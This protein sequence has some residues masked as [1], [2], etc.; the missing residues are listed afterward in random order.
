[1]RGLKVEIVARPVEVHG[2][3]EDR[4]HSI[5][6][7]ISLALYEQHFLGQSVRGVRLLRIPVPQLFFKKRNR[8]E[9]R[10]RTNRTQ[11][12]RLLN[13]MSARGVDELDAHD[14][15]VVK[16]AAWVGPIRADATH[17]GGQVNQNLWP[18]FI[19]QAFNRINA[20]KIVLAVNRNENVSTPHF[21]ELANQM[22]SKKPCS[23][24]HHDSLIGQFNHEYLP[25]AATAS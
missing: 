20:R 13:A 24:R 18:M 15:V 7:P 5:L 8:R 11:D 6:L 2:Q 12:N 1:M 19:K 9:L 16:E 25:S 17:N 10:V 22:S 21:L 23:A 14:R 4:V 3:K